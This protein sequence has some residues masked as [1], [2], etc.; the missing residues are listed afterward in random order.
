VV[1]VPVPIAYVA[2]SPFDAPSDWL[3]LAPL[4]V[5]PEEQGRGVATALLR[6]VVETLGAEKQTVVVLGTPSLF[7]RAGFSSERAA[8]L[9]T[10][11]PLGATLIARPGTD[12]PGVR[13][14]YN[15][16]FDAL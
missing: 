16:A 13:L 8:R 4:A 15:P 7:A 3:C 12:T 10:P 6:H 1:G 14:V 9:V 5:A 11:Y 2:V